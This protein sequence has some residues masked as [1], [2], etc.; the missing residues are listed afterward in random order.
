MDCLL[1]PDRL[2]NVLWIIFVAWFIL[3]WIEIKSEK[4]RRK[5]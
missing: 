1:D 4:R 3:S 2:K 5:K